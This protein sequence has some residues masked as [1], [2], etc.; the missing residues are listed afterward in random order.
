[1]PT[2]PKSVVFGGCAGAQ[3]PTARHWPRGG[4]VLLRRQKAW[5]LA[6][7]LGLRRLRRGTGRAEPGS[8]YAAKK[9]GF[10]RLRWGSGAYGAVLAARSP[11]PPTPPKSVVFGGCA[12]AQ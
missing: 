9:R 5:F 10:W 12:G 8:S 11:G 2:P 6:A 3:A 4:R 1:P 7:A